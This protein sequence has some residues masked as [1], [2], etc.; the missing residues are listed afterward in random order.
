[1]SNLPD[2]GDVLNMRG[3]LLLISD[4]DHSVIRV[5]AEECSVAEAF[6]LAAGPHHELDSR[7][8]AGGRTVETSTGRVV[9]APLERPSWLTDEWFWYDDDLACHFYPDDPE[10]LCPPD[11]FY[12]PCASHDFACVERSGKIAEWYPA[13]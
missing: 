2:F 4:W 13:D 11:V 1:M 10:D 3:R 12:L 6:E 5:V 7:E 9:F 8:D